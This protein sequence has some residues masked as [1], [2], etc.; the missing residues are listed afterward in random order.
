[1]EQQ[2]PQIPKSVWYHTDALF[3]GFRLVRPVK[4]HRLKR[5]KNIGLQ[6]NAI[7]SR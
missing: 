4:S 1:M 2:D 6:R 3:V 7:P 5:L